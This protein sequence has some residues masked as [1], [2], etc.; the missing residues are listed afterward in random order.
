LGAFN[1]IEN[2]FRRRLNDEK[3]GFRRLADVY[4]DKFNMRPAAL[5]LL[6]V[7]A[8]LRNAIVH[9][10]YFNGKPIAQP[11]AVIVDI[12]ESLRDKI[13]QP[14]TVWGTLERRAVVVFAPDD[15]ISSVLYAVRKH[16]YSQFPIYDRDSYRGLLT[17]N[18]VGRWL[19]DRLTTDELAES[20]P[21][22]SVLRFAEP[23]DSAL[24]L[25]RTATALHAIR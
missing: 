5:R 15:P 4:A 11:N 20:E 12:I 9:T 6:Y 2:H 1:A 10:N 23:Q 24:H 8:D 16:N 17:T 7:C 21:V 19:A 22:E 13:I 3:P 18:C 14:A 25:P